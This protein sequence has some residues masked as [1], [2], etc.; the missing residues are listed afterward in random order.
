M[1]RPNSDDVQL[2]AQAGRPQKSKEPSSAVKQ[3]VD[4]GALAAKQG[5]VDR[6]EAL[7]PQEADGDKDGSAEAETVS[8]N[9]PTQLEKHDKQIEGET[10][11]NSKIF[12]DI[13][14][15]RAHNIR[16]RSNQMR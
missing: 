2:E 16:S 6:E 11:D 10:S 12:K 5:E 15:N 4:P 9:W 13:R 3:A 1:P 14:V 8:T 7:V